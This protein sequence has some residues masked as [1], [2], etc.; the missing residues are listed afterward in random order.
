MVLQKNERAINCFKLAYFILKKNSI[1]N[2][3]FF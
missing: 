2:Q 3:V 1:Y